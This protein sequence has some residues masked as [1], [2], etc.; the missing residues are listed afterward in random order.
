MTT[1]TSHY[2]R[3]SGTNYNGLIPHFVLVWWSM[4]KTHTHTH[5]H[6]IDANVIA[7]KSLSETSCV[8]YTIARHGFKN[9]SS[10]CRFVG[11]RGGPD[12]RSAAKRCCSRKRSSLHH[13]VRQYRYRPSAVFQEI[14]KHLRSM[15]VGQ[16]TVLSRR[17]W[18]QKY[19][20]YSLRLIV[21]TYLKK[22]IILY[23]VTV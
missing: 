4:K 15:S 8:Q 13:Q 14:S 7:Y 5:T 21:L 22:T 3:S 16:E 9:C 6:A 20:L 19:V 1:I 18:T 17:S 11:V 23:A 2:R 12:G 10:L